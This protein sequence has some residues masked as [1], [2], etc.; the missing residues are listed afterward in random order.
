MNK[1][2]VLIFAYYSF[3][4]PVFQSAVL[5]YFLQFPQK[6]QYQFVLLTFEQEKYVLSENEKLV[7]K[8]SLAEQNIVWIEKKWHSGRFKVFKKI[9]DLFAGITSTLRLV[10]RYKV[11]AIYS[12]GFPGAVIAHFIAKFSGK[13]H[14]VHTFEPHTDYMVE[15]GVWRPTSWEAATL[16]KFEAVVAKGACAIMT[17]TQAYVEKWKLI[18][19]AK[20]YRVPSC[21]DL[22]HFQYDQKGRNKIRQ[23]FNVKENEIVVVYLGKLGGMYVEHELIQVFAAF[24]KQKESGSTYRF[25]VLTP[26]DTEKVYK[27]IEGSGIR[28]DQFIIASLVRDE[29]P[30]YLS[31]AD[32]AFCGIRPI[33]SRRYSSPIKNGEYWACGLPVI[34][35]DGISDDYLLAEKH[36]IGWRLQNFSEHAIDRTIGV[37]VKDWNFS[38]K[39][40]FIKRARG[41]V[42]K[43]RSVE[44]FQQLYHQIF[45]GLDS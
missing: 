19:T 20:I 45:T 41:F 15:S 40:E 43:D 32:I 16:K 23:R 30:A 13:P 8:H 36:R 1:R 44:V 38:K 12:E 27:L 42:E 39:E 22:D 10:R 25:M 4:D 28:K 26:E 17:A 2:H 14:I 11:S 33:P 37:V 5:P 9:Y 24:N 7:V 21:V 3:R 6:E 35:P 31:A 18:T 29:V 34:I